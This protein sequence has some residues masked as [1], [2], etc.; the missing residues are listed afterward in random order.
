MFY[1]S[2]NRGRFLLI[3]A[4]I[5]FQGIGTEPESSSTPSVWVREDFAHRTD[6]ML[7][8]F[9]VRLGR[10]EVHLDRLRLPLPGRPGWKKGVDQPGASS[11]AEEE[12][13]GW[14]SYDPGRSRMEP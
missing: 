1:F 7:H 8:V 9:S 3:A 6:S 10:D 5:C 2:S 12:V 11:P 14:G 4:L 13:R